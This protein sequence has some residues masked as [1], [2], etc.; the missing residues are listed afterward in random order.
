MS[1]KSQLTIFT[2]QRA[3]VRMVGKSYGQQRPSLLDGADWT[4]NLSVSTLMEFDN[5]NPALIYTTFDDVTLKLS[6]PQNNQATIEAVLA[7]IDPTSDAFYVNPALMTPF[8]TYANL[9]GLDGNIK[10]SWLVR[11]CVANANPFTGT[12]KEGAKRSLD[13]K[14]LQAMY[15]HGVGIAYT[16]FRGATVLQAPPVAAGLSQ[17]ASG[18]F[19]GADTYYFVLTAVTAVGETTPGPEASIQVVSGSVNDITVTTPAIAG[20]VTDYNI[21]MSDRSG[22]WRF[23]AQVSSGTTTTITVLPP[24][25]RQPSHDQRL[26]RAFRRQ[27]VTWCSRPRAGSIAACSAWLPS[28]WRRRAVPM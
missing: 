19:L 25:R 23:A 15:F 17:S 10:G 4:P 21:Y 22:A 14:A 3:A 20:S 1:S 28:S 8:Q 7:D 26:G 2:G 6:Y 13:A 24:Q 18:G 12:V 27:H 11:D 9:H 5:L 16:R